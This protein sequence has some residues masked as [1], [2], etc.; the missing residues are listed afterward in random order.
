VAVCLVLAQAVASLVLPKSYLLSAIS[1]SICLLLLLSAA[2]AFA[3]NAI[4]SHRRLRLVWLLLAVGYAVE[5]FGQILWM[6]WD[7]VFRQSP[8]MYL[9]DACIF[10]AWTAL[11]MGLALRPHIEPSKQQRRLGNLDLVLL[12][13]GG[14][15]LYLFLVIP[16]QY[17][18][19]DPAAYSQA[20]KFLALSQDV[21]LLAIVVLGWR[22]SSGRW[23]QFYILLTATIGFDTVMEYV[24]DTLGDA[25]FSGGWYDSVSAAGIAAITFAALIAYRVEP[26][27]DHGD[28]DS[29]RYWLWAARLAAPITIFLPLLA[30]WSFVD[31][32]L[33]AAVWTFRVLFSLA[34]T[35]VIALIGI[36]KQVRLEGE[37]ANANQEL[38]DA[39]VTDLLTGVRNRRFFSN[40]IDADVQQVFRTLATPGSEDNRNRDLVFYLID[41]D[42]FKLVNDDFGHQIGD[43]LLVEV[44][45]RITS[46]SR[47]SDGVIRWGGEEFLLISRYTDRAEGDV[48]ARRVLD[49]VGGKP[50]RVAGSDAEVRVTCSVG[51]AAFPWRTEDPRQISY[52]QVLL[53]ADYALYQAK[54][55]GRNRGVGLL[56]PK[57]QGAE[58]LF[59]N[60]IPATPVTT[61]GPA[62]GQAAAAAAK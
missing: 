1:D 35:I 21:L 19:R 11:I 12:F 22:Q 31:R 15:Y 59:I 17:L 32:S 36:V 51:W 45:R 43:Q 7:L 13:L 55:G 24:I 5:V 8:A 23:R 38:L 42:H 60:G 44:A 41:V 10:L 20:Y 54:G 39:S 14:L 4:Q 57:G 47:L 3:R 58:T 33:P 48:L 18:S 29:E 62:Q 28:C 50:C 53:L 16:W 37:L 27:A 30:A 34:A 6:R 61:M 52:E 25:Y 46:A 49:A 9:G 2:A 56:P 40:S 26:A